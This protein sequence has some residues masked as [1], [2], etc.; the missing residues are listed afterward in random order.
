MT[1]HTR[2][3]I[4]EQIAKEIKRSINLK[5]AARLHY[6]KTN[7]ETGTFAI[8]SWEQFVGSWAYTNWIKQHKPTI[9]SFIEERQRRFQQIWTD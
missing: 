5:Q 4:E 2:L 6:Y 8:A 9:D 3:T 1:N 7:M